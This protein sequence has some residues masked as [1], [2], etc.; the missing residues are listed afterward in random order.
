MA[1]GHLAKFYSAC[2]FA[3][4]VSPS[5]RRCDASGSAHEANVAGRHCVGPSIHCHPNVDLGAQR[6][7]I[8]HLQMATAT[9]G[10]KVEPKSAEK[11]LLELREEM[12]KAKVDAVVVPT[13]DPHL[14]ENVPDFCKRREFISG[15]SGSAGELMALDYLT[16]RPLHAVVFL[17]QAVSSSA[18]CE[19]R[20]QI[21]REPAVLPKTLCLCYAVISH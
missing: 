16:W 21:T 18:H 2:V 9:I 10:G 6:R 5:C 19:L 15:F 20:I 12:V 4:D 3:L 13:A 14:M 7:S 11:K 8:G 17:L 1:N